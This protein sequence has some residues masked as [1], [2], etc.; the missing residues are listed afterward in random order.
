M[1]NLIVLLEKFKITLVKI[2]LIGLPFLLL[3]N[4]RLEL[5]PDFLG[6][7]KI[8]PQDYFSLILTTT[9]AFL[10][11]VIAVVL[12]ALEL[13]RDNTGYRP[14]KESFHYYGL[15]DFSSVPFLIILSSLTSYIVIP[16][17]SDSRYISVAYLHGYLLLYFMLSIYPALRKIIGNRNLIS[18]SLEDIKRINLKT[19]S[20]LVWDNN[21]KY[22]DYP[23][24]NSMLKIKHDLIYFIKVNDI[25]SIIRLLKALNGK[26]IE[27][28][29]DGGD[30]QRV[31]F[32]LNSMFYVWNGG[33]GY[34]STASGFVYFNSI[35]DCISDLYNHS[36]K[37]H[38]NLLHYR[39]LGFYIDELIST[40]EKHGNPE[41]LKYGAKTIQQAYINV[42]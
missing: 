37:Y 34:A 32:M 2:T 40:I 1:N 9:A 6:F 13:I 8:S 35:W 26:V 16:D 11:I 19:V 4:V 23:K 18:D 17:F 33:K 41:N 21:E 28:I 12:V 38:I 22:A 10:G 42:V 30:R 5:I 25:S 29:G 14:E 7:E 27:I 39:D 3:L 31:N 36:S 24:D 20:E 15:I